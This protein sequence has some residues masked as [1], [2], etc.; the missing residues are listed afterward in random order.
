[1]E[2]VKGI[3]QIKLPLPGPG[4]DH[5]NA[6][7]VEG[8][9]GNLLIDTGWNTPEAFTTLKQDLLANGFQLKDITHVAVTHMHPDHYGLAGRIREISGATVAM[10]QAEAVMLDQRYVH[11]TDLLDS[12]TQFLEANG[13]PR[14]ELADLSAASL[15]ALDF[16]IPIQPDTMLNSESTIKMDPFEFKV[17]MTP[18]HSPG[19][20]CFYEPNKRYLFTGDH[21][22]P[23]IS[24]HVGLHPQSGENPLSDYLNS[25]TALHQLDVSFVFP[26]HGSVFSGLQAKIDGLL[27]H[28][29]ER[30]REI[31]KSIGSGPKTAYQITQEIPWM[32]TGEP[33][34]FEKLPPLDKRLAVLETLAHLQ[35]MI[36]AGKVT[37]STRDK[38]HYY[39]SLIMV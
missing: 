39:E 31:L 13:I 35:Y 38:I 5:V 1:M 25:L 28:H 7:L 4:L 26:G 22:L 24:P 27:T 3:Y 21:V 2:I 17:V 33:V 15:P 34:N 10:S 9:T 36:V 14:T 8:T 12:V 16:V 37:K 30:E 6:Y 18:G 23:D 20:I 11:V 32:P 29:K 19:H